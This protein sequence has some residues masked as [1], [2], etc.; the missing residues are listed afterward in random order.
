[1]PPH[2][3]VVISGTGRFVAVCDG[4]TVQTTRSVPQV[5]FKSKFGPDSAENVEFCTCS[6]GQGWQ[7]LRSA[8]TGPSPAVPVDGWRCLSFSSW[9]R[10]SWA[11]EWIFRIIFEAFFAPRPGGRECRVAGTL[12]V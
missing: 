8:T 5:Q 9:Q 3:L 7:A 10:W 11:E 12:G 2:Q 1:M 4:Q 6:S